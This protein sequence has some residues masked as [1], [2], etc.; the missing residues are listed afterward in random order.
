MLLIDAEDDRFLE[1]VAALPQERRDL[2]RNRRRASVDNQR[3]VEFSDGVDAVINRLAIAGKL[4]TCGSPALD[5]PVDVN[6]DHLVRREESVAD[7]LL[8]GVGEDRLPEVGDVRNV[9]GLLR[10]GG[11]ADLGRGGKILEDLAPRR[12]GCGTAPVALVDHDQVEEAGREL[13][14]GLLVLLR[15]RD[16]LIEAEIDLV[17]GVDAA[18]QLGHR[19]AERAEVVRHRL[20]DE[21]VAVG[22]EQDALLTSC[23]PQPP[24]DLESGERLARARGHD[25]QDAVLPLGDGLD[26]RV[27]G[28]DLVV[29]RCLAAAV[30]EVVL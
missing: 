13:L 18:R 22:K 17:G 8:E 25:Q 23:L 16:R 26:G 9:L 27:D 21:H 28:V 15:P 1:A 10:R 29:A 30:L 12:I 4:A 7:A 24:D 20:V 14:V 11:E 5:V 19:A 6:L 2:L 3:A